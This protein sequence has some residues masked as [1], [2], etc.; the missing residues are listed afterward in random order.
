MT[1][2]PNPRLADDTEIASLQTERHEQRA[3]V[4]FSRL[5][6]QVARTLSTRSYSIFRLVSSSSRY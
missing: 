6:K 1:D 3:L 2:R 4:A 5:D